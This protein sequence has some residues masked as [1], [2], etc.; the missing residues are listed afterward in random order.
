MIKTLIQKEIARQK[1]TLTL[2]PSENYAS[3][4]VMDAVGSPLMNK[5]AE[6]YPHKRYYNGN[7]IV[8]QME[9]EV[10]RLALK[11]FKLDETTW[12]ANVQAHS[13]SPA[14]LAAYTGMLQ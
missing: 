11:A 2:I 12:G 8:D 1:K 3:K 10:R 6:G 5:Y 14:N 9:D 7:E 13:G 4:A